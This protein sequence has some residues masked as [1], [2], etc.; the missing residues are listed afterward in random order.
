VKADNNTVY[1]ED[2]WVSIGLLHTLRVD[3]SNLET[4]IHELKVSS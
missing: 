2:Y 4:K 1:G 3:N